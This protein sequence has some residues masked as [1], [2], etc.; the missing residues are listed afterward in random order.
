MFA[1]QKKHIQIMWHLWVDCSAHVIV[2][3]LAFFLELLLLFASHFIRL[4]LMS[5]VPQMA[6]YIVHFF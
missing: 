3:L 2:L 6:F 1:R 4:I 5:K